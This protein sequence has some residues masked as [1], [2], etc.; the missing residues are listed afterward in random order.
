MTC[1][2]I[3][4]KAKPVD[5]RCS[6]FSTLVSA[7]YTISLCKS[8]QCYNN[9]KETFDTT[10]EIEALFL[11]TTLCRVSLPLSYKLIQIQ[12]KEYIFF[13]IH[14]FSSM[15]YSV[16]TA[17]STKNDLEQKK[18]QDNS[19]HS[20]DTSILIVHSILTERIPKRYL[21]ELASKSTV[22]YLTN[23]WPTSIHSTCM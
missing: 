5:A 2:Y 6:M 9:N 3:Y 11:Y 10:P 7:L 22:V 8:R 15:F 20:Q 21:N 16:L 17:G 18:R 4:C 1:I 13:C 19:I 12:S 23:R 14:T